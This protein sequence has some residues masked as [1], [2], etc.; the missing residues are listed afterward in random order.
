MKLPPPRPD[1]SPLPPPPRPPRGWPPGGGS[2]SEVLVG[3]PVP[4]VVG[5]Q[6]GKGQPPQVG[7]GLV[8]VG[9][10][11]VGSSLLVGGTELSE[12]EVAE[13]LLVLVTGA[14]NWP[15]GFGLGEVLDLGAVE[16]GVHE[17]LPDP[18]GLVL[19]VHVLQG[20]LH[21]AFLPLAPEN[22]VLVGADP[23]RGGDRRGVTHHPG[24]RVVAAALLL[25]V[26][27]GAGLGG[28]QPALVQ[29]HPE[30]LATGLSASVT[31]RAMSVLCLLSFWSKAGLAGS[32][33]SSRVL[34]VAS[35][36]LATKCC[37]FFMPSLAKVA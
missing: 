21:T 16:V 26:L 14:S 34:P 29:C 18:P 23:D 30:D 15:I 2:S 13:V 32:L 31:L 7:V 35:T 17:L 12:V 5:L 9:L 4:V 33:C 37:S 3:L 28:G 24:T 11:L 6:L 8:L 36:T 25:L 27:V 10:L 19:A 20:G 22:L 1:H